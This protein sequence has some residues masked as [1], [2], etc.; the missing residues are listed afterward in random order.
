MVAFVSFL[1][2][3]K[4]SLSPLENYVKLIVSKSVIFMIPEHF[5]ESTLHIEYKWM[6]QIHWKV[7]NA[8][9]KSIDEQFCI[10]RKLT[11]DHLTYLILMELGEIT[12]VSYK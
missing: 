5:I 8:K 12:C 9:L 6:F 11:W 3:S 7:C 10:F 4:I 1:K 2:L